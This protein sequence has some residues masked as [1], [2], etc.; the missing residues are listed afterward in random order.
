MTNAQINDELAREIKSERKIT[1]RIFKLIILTEDRKL[2]LQRGFSSLHKWLV[3]EHK[4]SAPAA[5]RRIQAA[6]LLRSVPS[7]ES[8]IESGAVNL[9]TLAQAQ[10]M[11]RTQEMNSKQKVSNKTKHEAVAKIVGLNSLDAEQSLM[12]LL[13]ENISAVKR[14]SVTVINSGTQRLSTNLTN[15]AMADL[16]RAK[17]LLAHTILIIG[18]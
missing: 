6:R 18:C 7:V 10:S 16:Q 1:N 15:Q 11:I 2:H 5:Y 13:P 8:K 4:Y 12:D 3:Q 14:E 9:T 17:E